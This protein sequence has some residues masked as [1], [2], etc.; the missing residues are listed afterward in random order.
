MTVDPI[1][2]HSKEAEHSAILQCKD[3]QITPFTAEFFA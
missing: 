1:K 3:S 2:M